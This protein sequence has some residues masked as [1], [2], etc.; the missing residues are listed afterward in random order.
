M[1]EVNTNRV[2]TNHEDPSR[3]AIEEIWAILRETAEQQK[4]WQK[5]WRLE[6]EERQKKAEEE[7]KRRQVEA[8]KR[9]AEAEEEAKKRQAEAEKR[10]AEAEK[11]QAEAEKEAERRKKEWEKTERVVRRTNKQ[12]S[13]L[14][15]RFG[16]LAE[17]RVAPSIQKRFNEL[18]YHFNELRSGGIR[19]FDE[20]GKTKTEIALSLENGET[21]MALEV[22]T[23][24]A[25]KDVEH[26]I[27]RLEI[28]RDHRRGLND[29]RTIQGAI[30]GAI[31]GPEEKKAVVEAGLYVV[32]Q[33][34]D[35]MRID[36]PD[37]FVPR[38]W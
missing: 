6:W 24:P 21:I 15:R 18:G 8:E 19:I 22:K 30:A 7:I 12:L 26:H 38:E 29:R 32:E 37:G 27:R 34:G 14:Y 20:Q 4:Q 11:R 23:K 13:D 10:Q 36:V 2:P 1:A 17:H 33:S 9:R 31:F 5:E 16:K 3:T 35:T 28:L 25:I